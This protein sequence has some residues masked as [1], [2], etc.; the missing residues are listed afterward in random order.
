MTAPETPAVRLFAGCPPRMFA[1]VAS[2]SIR[3]ARVL[4][5]LTSRATLSVVPRKFVPATVPALPTVLQSGGGSI[6]A[7]AAGEIA[8]VP[9]STSTTTVAEIRPRT[10][11][12][13]SRRAPR[14]PT[15]RQPYA[16]LRRRYTRRLSSLNP[17]SADEPGARAPSRRADAFRLRATRRRLG[18]STAAVG[19]R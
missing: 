11:D 9:T 7:W 14:A 19:G 8:A 18:G 16:R 4:L 10:P 2:G 5:T 15:V 6:P 12:P 3:S 1:L 17:A 13:L